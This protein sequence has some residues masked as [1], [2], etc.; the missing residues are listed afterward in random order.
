MKLRFLREKNVK[1]HP[2]FKINNCRSR[3]SLLGKRHERKDLNIHMAVP[4]P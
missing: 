1:A 4:H 2:D 3:I